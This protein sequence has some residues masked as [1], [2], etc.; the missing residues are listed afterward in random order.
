MKNNMIDFDYGITKKINIGPHIETKIYKKDEK[1]YQIIGIQGT[2]FAI[3]KE[4]GICEKNS[5]N[6]I[7]IADINGLN[8]L[9]SVSDSVKIYTHIYYLNDIINNKCFDIMNII[10]ELNGPDNKIYIDNSLSFVPND[11]NDINDINNYLLKGHFI[12][13]NKID[14][15]IINKYD[16]YIGTDE[17][18]DHL[19]DSIYT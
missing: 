17:F 9:N 12:I 6:N 13:K 16:R 3:I 15:I 11:I 4:I 5:K 2:G 7:L 14:N 1:M 8:S 10:V 19:I 18:M